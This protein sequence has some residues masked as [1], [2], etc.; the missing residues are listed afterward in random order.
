VQKQGINCDICDYWYHPKCGKLTKKIFGLYTEHSQLKWVC[1]KCV[2]LVHRTRDSLNQTKNDTAGSIVSIDQTVI[3]NSRTLTDCDSVGLKLGVE[4]QKLNLSPYKPIEKPIENPYKP[5]EKNDNSDWVEVKKTKKKAPRK[6]GIRLSKP[7]AVRECNKA[8]QNLQMKESLLRQAIYSI[9]EELRQH[10]QILKSLEEDKHVVI[11]K[12]TKLEHD[13]GLAMGRNRNVVVHGIHEPFVREGRQRDQQM[14][15]HLLNLL[16]IANIPG[17]VGIKRILRLGRWMGPR[18]PNTTKPR[19]MLVEFA[20]P[21]HRDRF[22]SNAGAINVATNGRVS[23]YPDDRALHNKNFM[24]PPTHFQQTVKE[25][26]NPKL[27]IPKLAIEPYEKHFPKVSYRDSLRAS[28]PQQN[29]R[30][31]IFTSSPQYQKNGVV[32]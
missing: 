24:N 20:N 13:T 14:Y 28:S 3:E 2:S 22:L 5:I 6:S 21:R 25:R 32:P 27:S 10:S 11:N 7:S 30:S 4:H 9:Q 23:V 12:L 26:F 8:P 18:D 1:P 17:D 19:P 15:H 31:P 16:R 29:I